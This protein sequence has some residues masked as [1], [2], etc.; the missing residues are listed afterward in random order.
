MFPRYLL[1][2]RVNY[3]SFYL[4]SVLVTLVFMVG[5][6]SGYLVQS[7]FRVGLHTRITHPNLS[8]AYS[9]YCV[10]ISLYV[11][12][13]LFLTN[14]QDWDSVFGKTMVDSSRNMDCDRR[15]GDDVLAGALMTKPVSERWKCWQLEWKRI[16]APVRICIY[17]RVSCSTA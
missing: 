16:L 11:V 17:R 5:F 8:H 3:V 13:I 6:R 14:L 12:C 7:K 2:I 10:H 4:N 15:D 9:C 1:L